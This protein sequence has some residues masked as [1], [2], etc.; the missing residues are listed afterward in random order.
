MV[1]ATVIPVVV[2]A[3]V[4]LLPPH[5]RRRRTCTDPVSARPDARCNDAPRSIITTAVWCGLVSPP[6][7]TALVCF[8]TC[9]MGT[10][11]FFRFPFGFASFLL[12]IPPPPLLSAI[13]IVSLSNSI[14]H[15]IIARRKITEDRQNEKFREYES[16]IFLS[17]LERGGEKMMRREGRDTDLMLRRGHLLL[18]L[19]VSF[20]MFSLFAVPLFQDI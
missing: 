12:F 8:H 13:F 19:R 3:F 7:E 1:A 17:L 9:E 4:P 16:T 11:F 2:A 15:V 5:N 6:Q 10:F 18:R 20:L 14:S